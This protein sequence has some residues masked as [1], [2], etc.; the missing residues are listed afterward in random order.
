MAS[1]ATWRRVPGDPRSRLG[2]LAREGPRWVDRLLKKALLAIGILALY[3][4]LVG[5]G[6]TFVLAA[7]AF[8]AVLSAA[9]PSREENPPFAEP[10]PCPVFAGTVEILRD[11]ALL[12]EDRAIVTLSDGWLLAE[13]HRTTFALRR[14]DVSHLAHEDGVEVLWL[15]GGLELRLK[16][17]RI[18]DA[19]GERPYSFRDH[20]GAKV[21]FAGFE[22]DLG[23][24]HR[25]EFAVGEPTMPPDRPHPSSFAR[26]SLDLAVAAAGSATALAM[27]FALGPLWGLGAFFLTPGPRLPESIRSFVRLRR[28]ARRL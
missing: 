24:W 28:V 21:R 6:A 4:L 3:A 26:S 10:S 25:G 11:G 19:G 22:H 27:L 1:R 23:D 7:L 16:C 5:G 17:H 15:D 8:C 9:F 12:G 18:R 2:W 14:N 20:P 13:G